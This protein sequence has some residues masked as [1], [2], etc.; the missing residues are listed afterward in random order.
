[1]A[2][3][4]QNTVNN[5]FEDIR[6]G[7]VV[8]ACRSSV[9]RNDLTRVRKICTTETYFIFIYPYFTIESELWSHL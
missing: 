7:K 2:L 9:M 1:M 3:S 8:Y 5:C 4:Y 6:Q